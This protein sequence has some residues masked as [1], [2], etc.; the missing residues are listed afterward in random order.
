MIKQTILLL[1][2]LSIA[3]MVMQPSDAKAQST[4]TN[5]ITINASCGL[6]SLTAIDF[7]SNDAGVETTEG[8]LSLEN[9]GNSVADVEMYGTD[10]L[11]NADGITPVIDGEQTKFATSD[12]G[13]GTT[14][15]SKLASNSTNINISMGTIAASTTNSTYWQVD[16]TLTSGQTSFVGSASQTLSFIMLC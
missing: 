7:G 1:A 8:I 10:W 13:S 5:A 4:V 9:T 3:T 14:Y 15:A 11:D 6:D 2:V 16:T 12:L